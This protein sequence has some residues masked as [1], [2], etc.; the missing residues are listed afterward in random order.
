MAN[1]EVNPDANYV[2]LIE[3]DA[4]CNFLDKYPKIPG[5]QVLKR[6]YNNIVLSLS[7][8]VKRTRTESTPEEDRCD[9]AIAVLDFC[10]S[11]V[12]TESFTQD[13][14]DSLIEEA[15]AVLLQCARDLKYYIM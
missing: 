15:R 4:I 8:T 7:S 13:D 1:S 14:K 11:L 6:K 3:A 10:K 12:I 9:E 5:A 2:K